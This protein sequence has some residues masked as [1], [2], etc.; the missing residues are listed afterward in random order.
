MDES[1]F[2]PNMQIMTVVIDEGDQPHRVDLGDV[3]PHV[4]A[5][6]FRS[7]VESLEE[8]IL[9]PVITYKGDTIFDV[10]FEFMDDD[11]D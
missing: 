10:A 1:E 2:F 9:P 6:V 5:A 11:D 7:I 8:L 4:A 3:P